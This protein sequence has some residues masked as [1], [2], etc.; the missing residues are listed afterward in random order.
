MKDGLAWDPS[1]EAV[2]DHSKIV[3][4][5]I[6]FE[7]PRKIDIINYPS[8]MLMSSYLLKSHIWLICVAVMPTLS[9]WTF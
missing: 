7:L 8:E 5:G 3:R 2:G 4:S 1:L 9:Y 6:V